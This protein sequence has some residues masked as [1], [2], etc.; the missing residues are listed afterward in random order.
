M[1]FASD[2]SSESLLSRVNPHCT[3]PA[4]LPNRVVM[5]SGSFRQGLFSRKCGDTDQV[6][7]NGDTFSKKAHQR[8]VPRGLLPF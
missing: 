4:H 2:F 6:G 5:G 7:M 8:N 3:P 1:R